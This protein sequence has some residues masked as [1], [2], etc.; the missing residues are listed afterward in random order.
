MK[1]TKTSTLTQLKDN[2][3]TAAV[4]AA[5]LITILGGLVNGNEGR[6]GQHEVAAQTM[7]TIVISAPAVDARMEPIVVTA[8]RES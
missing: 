1:T 4:M 7:D 3:A 6:A 2:V 8:K 5:I